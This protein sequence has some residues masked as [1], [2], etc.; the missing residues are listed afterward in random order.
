MLNWCGVNF[1]LSDHGFDAEGFC[2]LE[3]GGKAATGR[4]GERSNGREHVH[5]RAVRGHTVRA[6][7]RGHRTHPQPW[8]P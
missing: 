6:M 1:H 4:G 5:P 3:R 8:I 7:Q 2:V